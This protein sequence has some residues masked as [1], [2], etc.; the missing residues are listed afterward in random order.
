MGPA[1]YLGSWALVGPV[2]YNRLHLPVRMPSDG[3]GLHDASAQMAI[4]NLP[5]GLSQE[6]SDAIYDLSRG[7]RSKYQSRFMRY[8]KR[9]TRRRLFDAARE[10]PRLVAH[11]ANLSGRGAG[12]LFTTI[13]SEKSTLDVQRRLSKHV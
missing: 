8:V 5:Q 9:D 4:R 10:D 3:G 7:S 13:P 12:T 2:V 6:D 1:A 11:V